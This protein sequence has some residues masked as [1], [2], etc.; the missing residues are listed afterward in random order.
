[1]GKGPYLGA[2]DH[3]GAYF[4]PLKAAGG[5]EALEGREAVTSTHNI[6]VAAGG[7]R[8]LHNITG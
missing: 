3:K 2:R 4:L 5:N 6:T 7:S 8:K 1:M